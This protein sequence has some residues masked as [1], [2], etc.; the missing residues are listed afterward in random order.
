MKKIIIIAFILGSFSSA[1]SQQELINEIKRQAT[2]SLSKVI[3]AERETNTTNTIQSQKILRN[4]Q[5]TIYVLKNDLSK[6]NKFRTEKKNIDIKLITKS[7]SISLLLN[8]ILNKEKQIVLEKNNCELKVKEE[9]KNG[10]NSTLSGIANTYKTNSFDDLIQSATLESV[11]RDKALLENNTDL[12]HLFTDLIACFEAKEILKYKFDIS[13]VKNYQVKLAQVK[14]KSVA[15]EKLK[16]DIENYESFNSGL[17]ECIAKVIVYDKDEKKA[18]KVAGMDLET[19]KMKLNMIFFEISTFIFN[20]DFKLNDYPFLSDIVLEIF[21]RKQ[22]NPDA[23][24]AD[25]MQ[26]L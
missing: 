6:L 25:L 16:T 15:L 7:D 26:K 4:L 12:N 24:I 10:Q 19:Q 22:P 3:Q 9:Y 21:K 1:F 14:Q 2:D 13:K 17:K 5:D 11:K 8:T 18:F 20:Y 23:E